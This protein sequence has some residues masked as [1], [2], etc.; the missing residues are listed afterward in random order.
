MWL[1]TGHQFSYLTPGAAYWEQGRA[2]QPLPR[3]DQRFLPEFRGWSFSCAV[4][5]DNS[6]DFTFVN[7]KGKIFTALVPPKFFDR[8]VTVMTLSMR[9]LLLF[10]A[11]ED[12]YSAFSIHV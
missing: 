8:L 3:L 9:I 11:F 4:R 5:P 6:K 7:I 12:R 1:E 10:N 2:L